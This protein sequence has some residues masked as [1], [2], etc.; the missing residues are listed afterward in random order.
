MAVEGDVGGGPDRGGGRRP[1]LRYG[2]KGVLERW[3]GKGCKGE[4]MERGL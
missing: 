4:D 1:T 3:S 2:R